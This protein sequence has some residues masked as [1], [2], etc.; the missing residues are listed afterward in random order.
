MTFTSVRMLSLIAFGV[1][2]VIFYACMTWGTF[3]ARKKPPGGGSG[4]DEE[5]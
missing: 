5:L 1:I 4:M 3:F 2:L